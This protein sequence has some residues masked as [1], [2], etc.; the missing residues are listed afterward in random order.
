MAK[1]VQRNS[2]LHFR[3]DAPCGVSVWDSGGTPGD[4]QNGGFWTPPK[5][6]PKSDHPGAL[7]ID[8]FFGSHLPKTGVF[9]SG[10]GGQKVRVFDGFLD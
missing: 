8:V 9:G 1:D 10:G 7:L 4:P 6:A 3:E 5:G 2:A